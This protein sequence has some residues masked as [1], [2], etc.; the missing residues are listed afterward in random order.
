MF[1]VSSFIAVINPPES[2]VLALGAIVKRP[3][4]SE[5]DEIVVRPILNATL[6][7]DHRM[8]DGIMA[9]KFLK[10][11]KEVLENPSLLLLER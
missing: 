11:I 1:G 6:S 2:A 7:V 8:V 3:V 5:K 9:A 10:A 4:V